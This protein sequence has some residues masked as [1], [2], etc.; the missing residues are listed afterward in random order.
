MD[1][2]EETI[3][4][5]QLRFIKVVRRKIVEVYELQLTDDISIEAESSKFIKFV[6]I[7]NN[8]KIKNDGIKKIFKCCEDIPFCEL[9]TRNEHNNDIMADLKYCHDVDGVS[10]I[11]FIVRNVSKNIQQLNKLTT[12][13]LYSDTG[14]S[15]S[16]G[17]DI[18]KVSNT[19]D[20][21]YQST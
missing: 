7:K 21:F 11:E 13:F 20:D 15:L 6:A 14:C 9:E 2:P 1:L 16:I 8:Q 10:S 19:I 3:R 4:T 18:I 5:V 17:K 12:Y